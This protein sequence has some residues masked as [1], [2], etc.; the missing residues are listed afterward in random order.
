M[1]N[2][3][4]GQW[5]SPPGLK[6]I[7]AVIG[8]PRTPATMF[9]ALSNGVRRGSNGQ[10]RLSNG[11][12]DERRL[13]ALDEVRAVLGYDKASSRA[14]RGHLLLCLVPVWQLDQAQRSSSTRPVCA[15]SGHLRRR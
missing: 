2:P 8:T 6:S 13:P 15:R 14:E 1:S 9:H 11:M 3:F 12:D 4:R 7:W 10:H 5:T